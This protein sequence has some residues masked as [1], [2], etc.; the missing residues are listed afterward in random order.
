MLKNKAKTINFKSYFIWT[1]LSFLVVNLA[2]SSEEFDRYL[3]TTI[4][5]REAIS[6]PIKEL[7]Y[8]EQIL[9]T[10]PYCGEFVLRKGAP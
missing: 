8:E 4:D 10:G 1:L 7:L 5:G 9:P 2:Q 3:Q 6:T